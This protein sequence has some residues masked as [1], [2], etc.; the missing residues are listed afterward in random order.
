[1]DSRNTRATNP[2]PRRSRPVPRSPTEFF[3]SYIRLNRLDPP[4]S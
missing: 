1:M 4:F 3:V 2:V